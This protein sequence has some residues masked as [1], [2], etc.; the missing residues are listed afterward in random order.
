[1]IKEIAPK[2]INLR[3]FLIGVTD[4]RNNER[5]SKQIH[6]SAIGG[7]KILSSLNSRKVMPTLG[8]TSII[9]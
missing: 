4:L 1:M 5:K 2:T 6:I 7:E 9:I 8:Q 3:L